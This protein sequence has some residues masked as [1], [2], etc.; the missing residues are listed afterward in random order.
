MANPCMALDIKNLKLRT[1]NTLF[2]TSANNELGYNAVYKDTGLHCSL[3]HYMKRKCVLW[4]K[5]RKCVLWYKKRKCVL[6]YKKQV[7]IVVQEA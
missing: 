3:Q 7:C 4:Y 2:Q 5:K 1:A 6:W